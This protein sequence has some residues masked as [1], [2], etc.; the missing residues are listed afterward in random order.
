MSAIA[1]PG[2]VPPTAPAG[3]RVPYYLSQTTFRKFTLDEYHKMIESGVLSSGEPYELLEGNL[4]NKMPHGTAHDTAMDRMEGLFPTHALGGWFV[5]CQRA[6]TL[7]PSEPEPDYA[8]VR[9]PRSRYGTAHPTPV[10]IGLLIE[11]SDNSLM[12][13]RFDK[14][15]IYAEAGIPVYWVVNVVDKVV[16]VYTRPAGTGNAAA[17]ARRDDYPIGTAVPVILD[18]TAVGTVAVADALG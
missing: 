17:Y 6:I 10:E 1:P 3:P 18:G 2:V 15:R 8:I 5:R 13:D 9:G 11:V 16:E 12:I 4:V 7:A 14:G